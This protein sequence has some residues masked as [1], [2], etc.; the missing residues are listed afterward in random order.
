VLSGTDGRTPGRGEYCDEECVLDEGILHC[1]ACHL[2]FIDDYSYGEHM[3]WRRGKT[4][5]R[6]I[7]I[8]DIPRRV[9]DARQVIR[10]IPNATAN[11]VKL[12]A[13]SGNVGN[14][15]NTNSTNNKETEMK[16]DESIAAV[17]T[18][19]EANSGHAFL[20]GEVA[21]GTGVAESTTRSTLSALVADSVAA[22]RSRVV[23]GRGRGRPPVEYG[24]GI[25]TAE[26][27]A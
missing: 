18:F 3:R 20:P 25:E 11:N 15:S 22:K 4:S 26:V 14:A 24:V 12:P 8:A 1:P 27:T 5:L 2:S 16:R 9:I 17:R 23:E 10:V 19:L 13:S 21:A 6:C 7:Y